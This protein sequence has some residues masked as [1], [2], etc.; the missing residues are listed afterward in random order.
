M[1][2]GLGTNVKSPFGWKCD[3]STGEPEAYYWQ[4]TVRYYEP[5]YDYNQSTDTYTLNYD[6][7]IDSTKLVPC[8]D[9]R[10]S[11]FLNR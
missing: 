2:G 8:H 7:S 11:R 10:F 1:I 4:G 6:V 5:Y 9:S 3:P